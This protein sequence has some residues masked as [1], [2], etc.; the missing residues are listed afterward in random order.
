MFIAPP[1][2]V[3]PGVF[4]PVAGQFK[5]KLKTPVFMNLR[6]NDPVIA[7]KILAN[8]QADVVG[9]TRALICD[10]HMPNKANQGKMEEIRYCIGCNQACIGH[11][12]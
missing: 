10:P 9:M 5:T 8:G 4:A 3:E 2:P 7:D 1:A 6:V 12:E 11:M